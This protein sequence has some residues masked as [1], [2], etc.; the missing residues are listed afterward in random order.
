MQNAFCF[1]KQGL[2]MLFSIYRGPEQ[3]KNMIANESTSIHFRSQIR[4]CQEPVTS[5]ISRRGQ[6]QSNVSTEPLHGKHWSTSLR[7]GIFFCHILDGNETERFLWHSELCSCCELIA[8]KEISMKPG[9]QILKHIQSSNQVISK[10]RTD[11]GYVWH[12][13]T[14]LN[15]T[16]P[17]KGLCKIELKKTFSLFWIMPFIS[18]AGCP[19]AIWWFSSFQPYRNLSFLHLDLF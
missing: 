17:F 4:I 8:S 7:T 13:T 18:A 15:N 1:M 10:D 19:P 14:N 3:M 2:V 9:W 5:L 12:I 11:T 6:A 16:S